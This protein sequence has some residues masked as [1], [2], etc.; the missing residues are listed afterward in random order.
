M[1]QTIAGLMMGWIL[2]TLGGC[3]V[4]HQPRIVVLLPDDYN[5]PD[6]MI[7][8]PDGNIYLDCPNYNQPEYPGKLLR[9]TKDDIVEEVF[10]YPA[11]P[12][13]GKSA[14]LG[15]DIGP[16]G[17]FYVTDNQSFYDKN[18]QSRLL[19]TNAVS[20]RPDGVYVTETQMDPAAWPLP[21]G[22]YRFRYDEFGSEPIELKPAG[23]DAHLI[24][25]LSTGNPDW[26]VGANGM[27]F[28]SKGNMYV[29]NFGEATIVR[30]T[31][32]VS[33][34]ISGPEIFAAGQGMESVDGIKFDPKNDDLFVAD[35]A[36]NAV[37]RID[38]NGKVT[39]VWKNANDSDGIGGLLDRPSEVCLRGNKLYI[40][41]IDLPVKGNRYDPLHTIS[42]IDVGGR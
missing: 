30:Y 34:A 27:G 4:E 42:V 8:A 32:D 25:R 39:T 10:T 40:S 20:C 22:V 24:V 12:K 6:G 31:F 1:R 2:L 15:I 29:C 26:R 36:G 7:L 21:S 41:N 16:D 37:H 35:F 9:I 3:A 13:T 11:H 23:K 33:G 17:N 5:T 14:P 19:R 28:D 18:N 38:K